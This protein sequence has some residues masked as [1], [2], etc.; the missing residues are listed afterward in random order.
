MGLEGLSATVSLMSPIHGP[1]TKS[2]YIRVLGL[3][4]HT[5][6][7]SRE[8]ERQVGAVGCILEFTALLRRD[9]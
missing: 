2:S 8:R 4:H 3:V 9:R 6:G 7:G 5:L 1:S